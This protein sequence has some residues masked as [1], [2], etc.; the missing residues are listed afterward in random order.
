YRDPE[1]EDTCLWYHQIWQ[2]LR[3][4]GVISSI[5]TNTD[6]LIASFRAC[7]RTGNCRRVL[8]S[9]T[10]DYSMLAHVKSAY[11]EEQSALDATVI[12]RC[13]T[14]LVL[15]RWY[16]DRCGIVLATSRADVLEFT[17]ANPFDMVCTHNFLGRFDRESRGRL[18]AR[19]HELLRPGGVVVTTQRV[20]PGVATAPSTYTDEQVQRLIERV[21][22]A[23]HARSEPLGV[24]TDALVHAVYEYA[25][26]RSAHAIQ[27][28]R[29]IT[30]LF[31]AEGFDVESSDQGDG[32]VER[33]RDRP[34]SLAGKDTYR[35]RLVA[36][37]R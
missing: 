32:A 24:D 23:V 34:L 12:D 14:S 2:Y 7:A 29:E 5:R 3:L 28:T 21:V 37:K 22:T 30:D 16:A 6:F 9:A 4:L 20:R 8:V 10:A 26:R 27:T 15:N 19:W 33:E 36:R 1:T 25:I 11:D 13:E 17:T 18:V 35:M 31:E